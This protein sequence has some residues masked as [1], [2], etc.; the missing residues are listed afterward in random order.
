MQKSQWVK[1]PP[2]S[3]VRGLENRFTR[4]EL[5]FIT[6][7]ISLLSIHRTDEFFGLLVFHLT[8]VKLV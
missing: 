3:A 4:L 1:A 6:R 2:R 5:K 7:I 8:C